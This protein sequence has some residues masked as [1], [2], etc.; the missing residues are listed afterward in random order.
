MMQRRRDKHGKDGKRRRFGSSSGVGSRAQ[1]K[2]TAR[3]DCDPASSCAAE[4]EEQHGA[5]R[6]RF[7]EYLVSARERSGKTL[8]EIAT[9]TRIPRR[10]LE[11]LETGDFESLPGDVFVR[12]FLRSYARCVGLDEAEAIKRYTA[13]GMTPA[14]VASPMADELAS[15][16]ATL[17]SS[18]APHIR[19]VRVQAVPAARPDTGQPANGSVGTSGQSSGRPT[20]AVQSR[21]EP[22]P[23][24]PEPSPAPPPSASGTA[25]SVAVEPNA[26]VVANGAATGDATEPAVVETNASSATPTEPQVAAESAAKSERPV[27]RTPGERDSTTRAKPARAATS[28]SV[29]KSRNARKRARKRKKRKGSASASAAAS[30][31]ADGK[32]RSGK[33]NG[34]DSFKT[35]VKTGVEAGAKSGA[36]QTASAAAETPAVATPAVPSVEPETKTNAKPQARP[37][38]RPRPVLRI[39][40]AN[41]E[42]AE[43]EQAE[44]ERDDPSWKSFIPPSLLDSEQGSR[45]GALTLAVIILVIVATLTMSYLMRQPDE[46][47]DGVTRNAPGHTWRVG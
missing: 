27:A 42:Q 2:G 44:R 24:A 19:A 46:A 1:R 4:S 17:E 13:C 14:P 7:C 31:S 11:R 39:D 9:K 33:N 25:G 10:S 12:G 16:M 15:A 29:G 35:S 6:E 41:P 23:V 8:D 34:P 5:S 37:R 45:R 36:K 22:A 26:T 30:S 28:E 21:A 47:G 3:E 20:E 38:S 43:R 18:A 32:R 40:D